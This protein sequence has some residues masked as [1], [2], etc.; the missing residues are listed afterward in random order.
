MQPGSLTPRYRLPYTSARK[1]LVGKAAA[2]KSG[3]QDYQSL[4]NV[5]AGL[6]QR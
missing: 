5:L 4:F 2:L 3:F 1:T 6:A